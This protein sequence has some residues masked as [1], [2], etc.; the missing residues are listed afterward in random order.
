MVDQDRFCSDMLVWQCTA[1]ADPM[2]CDTPGTHAHQQQSLTGSTMDR[3]GIVQ[4]HA[5]LGNNFEFTTTRS[6]A[7]EWFRAHFAAGGPCYS[8]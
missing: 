7:D 1:A 3:D 6:S 2:N 8:S 4:C 5:G